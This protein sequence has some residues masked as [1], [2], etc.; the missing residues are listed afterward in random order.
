MAQTTEGTGLVPAGVIATRPLTGET[1][2]GAAPAVLADLPHAEAT[3]AHAAA[4]AMTV[5]RFQ[6]I[7]PPPPPRSASGR[8]PIRLDG[9]QQCPSPEDQQRSMPGKR[10]ADPALSQ[11]R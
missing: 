8:S 1:L 4:T 2:P 10:T 9:V 11:T 5:H 6:P 7:C 3:S